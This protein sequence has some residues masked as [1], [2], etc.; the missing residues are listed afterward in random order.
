MFR[1]TARA[2]FAGALSA[3]VGLTG[4]LRAARGQ[5][6]STAISW[7][8]PL[9]DCPDEAYVRAAV[10][11]LLGGKVGGEVG[12]DDPGAA[13]VDAHALV[14]HTDDGRWRVRLTTRRDGA[15]GERVVDSDSCRS[16][17]D[18]TALI[19]ALA[20]DPQ[21]V[22][23]NRASPAASA[24]PPALSTSESPP[25]PASTPALVPTPS[26]ASTPAPVLTPAPDPTPAQAPAVPAP[27]PPTHFAAF[28]SLSGDAGTLPRLAYG[29]GLGAAL[30][31]PRLRFEAYGAYWPSHFASGSTVAAGAGGDVFLVAGG[32]RAC[33]VPV[34]GDNFERWLEVA[35]CPGLEAGDMHGQG[36]GVRFP[37]PEDGLWF[38]ATGLARISLR[39]GPRLV[40]FLDAAVAVPFAPTAFSLGGNTIYRPSPVEGRASLGPELRF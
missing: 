21:R 33:W 26:P 22:S 7:I 37:L 40:L 38:A 29:F 14:T 6:P 34:S 27:F 9:P 2:T 8:A 39:V 19:V 3:A 1:P 12:G 36:K 28:A 32:L 15:A 35:A 11:Q 13:H 18:A 17:A 23:A 30:L 31:F 5:S 16:L 25:A 24:P 10:Q 4:L 20:I